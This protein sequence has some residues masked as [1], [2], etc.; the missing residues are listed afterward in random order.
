[1]MDVFDELMWLWRNKTGNHKVQP[2]SVHSIAKL[3]DSFN[4]T[5][6]KAMNI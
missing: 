1:M 3:T 5:N 4:V 6:K 2:F